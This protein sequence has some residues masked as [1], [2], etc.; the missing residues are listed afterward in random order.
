MH[1]WVRCWK[2][3]AIALPDRSARDCIM[4][5]V[6]GESARLRTTGAGVLPVEDEPRAGDPDVPAGKLVEL[7]IQSG[8]FAGYPEANTP[9]AFAE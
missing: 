9:P 1:P 7:L 2:M 3:L 8:E 4:E 5:M 6:I